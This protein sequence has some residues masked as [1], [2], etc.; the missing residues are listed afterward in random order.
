VVRAAVNARRRRVFAG[1]VARLPRAPRTARTRYRS[2]VRFDEL[3]RASLE[4]TGMH[5]TVL[6]IQQLY[7]RIYHACHAH[8]VRARSTPFRVSAQD[9]AILAHVDAA[10]GTTARELAAHLGVGAPAMSAAIARLERLGYVRRAARAGRSPRR[11]LALTELGT[12]ALQATSVLDTARLTALVA[13]LSARDRARAVAGLR[14]LAD[15]AR[16]DGR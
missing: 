14:L 13:R 9:G 8:H 11:P 10:N 2:L 7:P 6:A 3:R 15:A 12:R 5:P 4:A 16:E 1:A